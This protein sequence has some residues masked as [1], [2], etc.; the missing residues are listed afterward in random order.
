MRGSGRNQ[1]SVDYILMII[2]DVIK[3]FMEYEK[4][5]LITSA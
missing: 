3:Y 5:G 4:L 2:N 1:S